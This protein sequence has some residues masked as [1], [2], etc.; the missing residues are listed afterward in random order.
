ME[1]EWARE[2]QRQRESM[3]I[4]QKFLELDSRVWLVRLGLRA[5]AHAFWGGATDVRGV[6]TEAQSA[7]RVA[8]ARLFS[9]RSKTT[10]IC[11][12]CHRLIINQ[13]SAR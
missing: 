3:L 6:C 1:N 11:R 4:G 13:H 7:I 12:L 8:E 2:Q 10:F 5:A 9:Q